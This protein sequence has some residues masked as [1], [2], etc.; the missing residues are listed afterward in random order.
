MF[1]KKWNNKAI[2]LLLLSLILSSLIGTTSRAT[3]IDDPGIGRLGSNMET[4]NKS[5]IKLLSTPFYPI[6]FNHNPIYDD[7]IL[8]NGIDVSK[9]QAEID[10]DKAKASGVDFA[11]IRVGF[12][13]YGTGG[14]FGADAYYDQ[15]MQGAIAAGIP[16][17]VYF[18][19]QAT[20]EAEA[21]EEANYTLEQISRYQISLPIVMDFE[22]ASANGGQTGRLYDANLSQQKATNVCLAFCNTIQSSG[23]TPM[24]YANLT[25][26]KKG[27]YADQ[28][29]DRY[30]IWL[31]NY[32]NETSYTGDYS[33]WQ[34]TSSGTVDG[35][36]G[37]VDS[38]FWYKK[39]PDKVTNLSTIGHSSSNITLQWKKT[40][41]AQGYQL[42]RSSSK[43]GPY[44]R[45]DSVSGAAITTYIDTSI[46]SSTPYYYKVRA[47]LKF[48]GNNYFGSFSSRI[49]TYT[50]PN[51]VEQVTAKPSSTSSITVKWDKVD[52]CD[53]YRVY[54]YDDNL[55][56]F[57]KLKTLTNADKTTYTHTNL[58][59]ATNYQYRISAFSRI[60]TKARFGSP[61]K[62]IVSS[63]LP[64]KIADLS[65]GGKTTSRIRLN[66]SKVAGANG[67]QIYFYDKSAKKYVKL[68]T[69]SANDQ[70]Y[71]CKNLEKSTSYTFK[72]RAYKRINNKN[73]FGS[74]HKL[75]TKTSTK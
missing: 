3:T 26:L 8:L 72:I 54:Y 56:K 23:Y 64:V 20:S 57:V 17:G 61:S 2:P 39:T 44:T 25:M 53:G 52:D 74:F 48:G 66:W 21:I 34:Y 15:N 42:Y 27:L 47:Y 68:I 51:T 40:N 32:T 12:R 75:R 29:S 70:T 22:Y 37:R 50:L 5:G 30:D 10:W 35:I 13:G 60:H 71:V 73:Y 19:S 18:F 55:Q 28:I 38:N 6:D 31:A 36:V 7:C 24:V 59:S 69:V 16:V 45:I 33:F 9:Y 49:T 65:V 63:P 4:Q 46:K 58:D 67:Y 11:F 1:R 43:S 14:N 62:W 41:G